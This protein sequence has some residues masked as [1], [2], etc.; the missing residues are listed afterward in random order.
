MPHFT[1]QHVHALSN[2][3]CDYEG[4]FTEQPDG[5]LAWQATVAWA[6]GGSRLLRGTASTEPPALV[7]MNAVLADLHRRI[8]VQNPAEAER[9]QGPGGGA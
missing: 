8:D 4:E 2:Q 3:P 5:L 9:G 6:D 1:G 7:G